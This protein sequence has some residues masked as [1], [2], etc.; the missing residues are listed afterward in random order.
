MRRARSAHRAL[1]ARRPIA[2]PRVLSLLRRLSALRL[3]RAKRV[4]SSGSI[5]RA[6]CFAHG[7]RTVLRPAAIGAA[8]MRAVK[9]HAT[10]RQ[11]GNVGLPRVAVEARSKDAPPPRP[12]RST[13]HVNAE[14]ASKPLPSRWRRARRRR[15]TIGTHVLRS[16]EH[17]NAEPSR[18]L[19]CGPCRGIPRLVGVSPASAPHG[20][21][22][23]PRGALFFPCVAAR[24]YSRS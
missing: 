5:S 8:R 2:A 18:N 22:S 21:C 16:F 13:K 9:R 24:W 3:L 7:A 19:R 11:P 4:V 23:S 17:L 6:R 10:H 20:G 14:P 12:P 15:L 1:R